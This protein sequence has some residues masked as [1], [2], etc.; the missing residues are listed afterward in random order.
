MLILVHTHTGTLPD[1]FYHECTHYMQQ[2][3][4]LSQIH[5]HLVHLRQ[6]AHAHYFYLVDVRTFARKHCRGASG[7]L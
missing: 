1:A 7:V 4:T 5:S 6:E 3:L 2:S